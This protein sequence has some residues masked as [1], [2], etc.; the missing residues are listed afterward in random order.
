MAVSIP[1]NR[2]EEFKSQLLKKNQASISQDVEE[3]ILSMYAK[4]ITT[5]DIEVHIWDIDRIKVSDTSI[6]RI[7]GKILPIVKEG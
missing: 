6:S 2:K 4:G 3:K 5:D 1:G 7:T